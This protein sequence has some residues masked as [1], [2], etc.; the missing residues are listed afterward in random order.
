MADTKTKVRVEADENNRNLIWVRGVTIN[1]DR[2]SS[3]A[4]QTFRRNS[5]CYQFPRD[6]W[7][8]DYNERVE[9]TG[10]GITSGTKVEIPLYFFRRTFSANEAR[11]ML[12]DNKLGYGLPCFLDPLINEEIKK[13]L[14][15]EGITSALALGQSDEKLWHNID[16]PCA[17]N[18]VLG[19]GDSLF[20]SPNQVDNIN[21]GDV[22]VVG[23]PRISK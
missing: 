15:A 2:F 8:G 18:L 10:L 11:E 1:P 9:L 14:N 19:Y 12:T 21:A 4:A 16:G 17:V 6:M 3:D 5:A 20:Y 22:A 7:D 13:A 23:F